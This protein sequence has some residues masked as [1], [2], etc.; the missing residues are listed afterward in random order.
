VKAGGKQKLTNI[1]AWKQVISRNRARCERESR[2]KAHTK[3]DTGESRWQSSA[4]HLLSRYLAWPNFDPEERRDMF[5]LNVCWLLNAPHSVILQ[6]IV[7]P[8]TTTVRNLYPINFLSL[9]LAKRRLRDE[10]L[11]FK[12]E[13][14]KWK[15]KETARKPYSSAI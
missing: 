3:Q 1:R 8:I 5:L 11:N 14:L 13:G 6:T 15:T 12:S 2:W 10:A 4:C 9:Q 7:F